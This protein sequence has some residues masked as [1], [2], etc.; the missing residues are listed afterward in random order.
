MTCGLTSLDAFAIYLFLIIYEI[1]GTKGKEWKYETNDNNS[2]QV[3][4]RKRRC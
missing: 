4:R 1:R 3:T 2:N